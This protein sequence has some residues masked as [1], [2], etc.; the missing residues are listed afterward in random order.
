MKRTFMTRKNLED[1][2]LTL[3]PEAKGNEHWQGLIKGHACSH[4]RRK[5][6]TVEVV[7]LPKVFDCFYWVSK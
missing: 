7:H 6:Y 1:F 4:T 3:Y 5:G 2:V